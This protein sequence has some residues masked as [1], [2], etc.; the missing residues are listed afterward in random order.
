MEVTVKSRARKALSSRWSSSGFAITSA[1]ANARSLVPKMTM[2]VRIPISR[3]IERPSECACEILEAAFA[4]DVQCE[5]TRPLEEQART[6]NGHLESRVQRRA[7]H[8]VD[9]VFERDD[10]SV[11]HAPLVH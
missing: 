8:P 1:C 10:F 5:Q 11:H 6:E 3:A 2:D 7:H 4:P 9:L